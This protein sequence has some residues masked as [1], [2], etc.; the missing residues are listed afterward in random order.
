MASRVIIRGLYVWLVLLLGPAA[1]LAYYA[2]Q[3]MEV[4]KPPLEFSVK[5]GSS[6]RAVARQL[7][8]EGILPNRW[9][10]VALAVLLN[11]ADKLKAGRYSLEQR[12][13]PMELLDKITRG[14]VAMSKIML[15]E[16]WTFRQMREAVDQHPRLVH[17]TQGMSDQALL[18][19]IGA[20]ETHPEGLFFP[21]TYFFDLDSSD[22]QLYKRA[23]KAMQEKLAQA[24]AAR[25][26][27]LPYRSPYEVLIMAS[28]IERET[29][30]PEERPL[31]AA[32]FINRLRLGMRLQTDPTVIYG[33]GQRFDGNLRKD[34]LL[35]DTPYNTYTRG[36]LPPTPIAL[37]GEAAIL[38]ALNPEQSRALYFVSMGE[39]RH[40]FSN[41]LEEH[42]RAVA[43]Y[44]KGGR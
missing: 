38:A 44:Q 2:Y 37:P 21:A 19:A 6:T 10:F 33:L 17:E 20:A 40:I 23:Y 8:E 11:R 27:G 29:G 13:T 14:D 34:D 7:H 9:G 4:V 3:P 42:N 26:P 32:V 16:G 41:T 31:I 12:Y 24:W 15:V 35:T 39:G 30:A 18:A 43:R 5:P 28:V 25:A 36:G 22:L 1:W